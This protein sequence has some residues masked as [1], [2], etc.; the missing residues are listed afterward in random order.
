MPEAAPVK[1]AAQALLMEKRLGGCFLSF[2]Y[3]YVI[4][5]G[6]VWQEALHVQC[7]F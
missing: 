4:D 5:F 3:F 1:T 7:F 2:L 6:S